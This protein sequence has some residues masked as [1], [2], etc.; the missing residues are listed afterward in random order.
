[1]SLWDVPNYRIRA[2]IRTIRASRAKEE[3]TAS[4]PLH[5]KRVE[6]QVRVLEGLASATDTIPARIVFND[7]SAKGLK[8]FSPVP[9]FPGQTIAI[10]IEAPISFYIKGKVLG[11]REVPRGTQVLTQV[12]YDFRVTVQF[13]FRSQ[14]E[15]DAVS[16]Y[17][18]HIY[19]ELLSGP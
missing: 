8:L 12:P 15:Q 16:A 19:T 10:A 11:C 1:M 9:F 13:Q 17:C 18:E 3:K 4:A 7:F 6:A 5:F 14:S 2:Y